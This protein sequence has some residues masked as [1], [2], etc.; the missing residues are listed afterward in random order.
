[1][2]EPITGNESVKSLHDSA[3]MLCDNKRYA[4]AA[5]LEACALERAV[6][7]GVS[8]RTI[9]ILANGLSEIAQ[10]VRDD[11]ARAAGGAHDA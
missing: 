11:A 6:S 5:V 8:K 7:Q 2:P 10:K 1:M 4:E 9:Y 3:M